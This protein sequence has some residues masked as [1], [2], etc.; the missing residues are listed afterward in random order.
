MTTP[1]LTKVSK[2]YLDYRRARERKKAQQREE[3]EE[4]S[5]S[6]LVALGQVIHEARNSGHK[7]D[8][9]MFVMGLKNR[10]FLYSALNAYTGGNEF[11]D[12][13]KP[14]H[15]PET[16]LDVSME[17]VSDTSVKVRIGDDEWQLPVNQR[18]TLTAMPDEW[19]LSTSFE[20]RQA[21]QQVVQGVHELWQ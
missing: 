8:E 2:N 16:P 5:A 20:Y 15:A 7:I 4:F 10:N 19:L 13:P 9:I 6:Y 18:G 3:L 12:N 1:F 21:V 11:D 14:V 17:R